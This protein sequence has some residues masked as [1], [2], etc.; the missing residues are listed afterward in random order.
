[1]EKVEVIVNK[2][3]APEV[4]PDFNLRYVNATVGAKLSNKKPL[5]VLG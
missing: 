5:E 1:M 3:G 2:E 4:D